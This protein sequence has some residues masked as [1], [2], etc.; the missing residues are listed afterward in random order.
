MSSMDGDLELESLYP[1][2]HGMSYECLDRFVGTITL[3][4]PVGIFIRGGRQPIIDSPSTQWLLITVGNINTVDQFMYG[5]L[6]DE[7][8]VWVTVARHMI[9]LHIITVEMSQ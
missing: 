9:H 7:R 8:E 4:K 3:V 1:P 5:S 6:V 2:H